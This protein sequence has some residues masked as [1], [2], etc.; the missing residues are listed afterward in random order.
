MLQFACSY[1]A[2][3]PSRVQVQESGVLAV[4]A[5]AHGCMYDLAPHLP[6]VMGMLLQMCSA[7]KPL[8]RSISC[9]CVSRCAQG[10]ACEL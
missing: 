4:G 6:N 10:C 2:V 8:L 7:Q 1:T 5:I 9:W 3:E